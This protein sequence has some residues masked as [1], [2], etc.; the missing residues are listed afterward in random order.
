MPAQPVS[1]PAPAPAPSVN[2]P[3]RLPDMQISP[4]AEPLPNF[5][6]S[7]SRDGNDGTY[8]NLHLLRWHPLLHPHP[9]MQPHACRTHTSSLN[10]RRLQRQPRG[11]LPQSADPQDRR[12][13]IS[14]LSLRQMLNHISTG[15]YCSRLSTSPD[16]PAPAPAPDPTLPLPLRDPVPVSL[17]LPLPQSQPLLAL[18]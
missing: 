2:I 15:E 4:E 3:N 11:C 5:G 7:Y 16:P 10:H 1:A 6:E 14:C 9:P 17:P 8:R 12:K 18:P 13:C